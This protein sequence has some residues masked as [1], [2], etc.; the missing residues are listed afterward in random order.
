MQRL[1]IEPVSQACGEPAQGPL[2]PYRR[3]HL[4]PAVRRGGL[5][6]PAGVHR[7]GD[8]AHQPRLGHPADDRAR[9]RR[10][11]PRSRSSTRRTG[12]HITDGVDLLRRAAARSDE[13]Q[14]ADRARPPAGPA[15][16]RPAAGPDGAGGRAQRLRARGA[17][18]RRRAVDPGPAGAAGREAGRRPTRAR[19]V[20]RPGLGLPHL[21][22]LWDYLRGAA[23]RAVLQRVPPDVPAE[24]LH[25]LRVREW[26]DLYG[27]LRQVVLRQLGIGACRR[28]AARAWTRSARAPGRCW[29]G[30]SRTS[31]LRGR[32]ARRS[33]EYAGARGA[34]FAICPGSALAKK[35][36]RWVMAAEL[37][38]T[39]RLWARRS[40]GSSR[41]GPSRWP[42]TWST[43]SY[44]EPHWSKRQAAVDGAPSGSR[45]TALPIVVGRRGRLRPDRPGAVPGAVHPARAGRGRL[46]DPPP[47]L[48]RQPGAAARTSRSWS[49]GPAGADI[50]VDDDDAVR[51][52]RPADPGRRRLR[53]G[54]S[55]RGG[56]RPGGPTPTCSPSPGT[57]LV[58][59]RPDVDDRRLPRTPGRQGGLTLPLTYQFEPG[60]PDDGVTVRRPAGRCST[61]CARRAST[62]RCRGC[63]RSW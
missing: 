37:V 33:R 3:R 5:R 13:R 47:V 15:A 44:S 25:Y 8:P 36:P 27:Q 59:A 52:L 40:P 60:A 20:R 63:A 48:R 18:D 19:P 35:P 38:E 58:S 45:C 49:T 12:A 39:S 46:A 26:Q 54:T 17:G 28:P 6:R 1:P 50:L 43:R 31:G 30:C 42:A 53:R 21:L 62:G 9:A 11:R 51:L 14:P 56:R 34:R 41:S 2:R 24:F 16:G 55:T 32:P 29:P 23:E 57:M 61:R 22:N 7:A 4:H 10:R